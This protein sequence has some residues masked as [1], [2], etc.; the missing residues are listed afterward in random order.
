MK[1]F[2]PVRIRGME[3][4]NRVIMPAMHLNLG[5]LG[6]RAVAFYEERA[7]G[8]VGCITTDWVAP[9]ARDRMRALTT[10]EIKV[11]I[12]DLALAAVKI[13]EAGFDFVDFN[14]AH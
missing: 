13:Q 10:G 9:S 6:K 1:L 12:G 14:L 5:F 2:E 3:L 11:I 8:G 7:K 4:K